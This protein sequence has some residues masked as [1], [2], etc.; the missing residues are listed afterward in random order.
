MSAESPDWPRVKAC[1][2][3]GDDEIHVWK[4]GI[5]GTDSV[6]WALALL[7]EDERGRAAG[8]ARE[9]DR[10]R[11]A[12]T[13]AALRVLLAGYL[14]RSPRELVLAC[15]RGGKPRLAEA[16]LRFNVSHS[17]TLALLAFAFDREIGVDLEE[18]RELPDA[19]CIAR[20]FFAPAER[21]ALAS[22]AE[23]EV[24][25]AFFRCWT[26][27]EAFIKATGGGLSHPL[28]SFEV[29]FARADEP[30]PLLRVRGT[31][32]E[33]APFRLAPLSPGPRFAGALAAEGDLGPIS[34][35]CLET[36]ECLESSGCDG[37]PC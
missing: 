31:P 20:R 35:Y 12:L 8:F 32:R 33:T 3:L 9:R 34:R 29:S 4:V 37:G 30:A 18:E 13:R 26:R 36:V 14:G 10:R 22:L 23:A 19:L 6:R 27:K 25:P 5:D 15:G 2:R 11:F 16:R 7:S 28:D 1:P 21:R 24:I 17:G